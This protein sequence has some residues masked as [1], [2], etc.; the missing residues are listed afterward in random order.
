VPFDELPKPNLE[1]LPRRVDRTVAAQLLTKYF[2]RVSH[3]TLERWPLTWRQLNGRSHCE[4][5]ELF[6]IAEAMLRAAPS[7]A[8]GRR[9]GKPPAGGAAAAP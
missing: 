9:W 2:F 5:V 3:R 6:R 7:V 1:D 8:G 4:T